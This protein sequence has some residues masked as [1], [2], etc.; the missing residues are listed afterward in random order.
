MTSTVCANIGP[1]ERRK[2]NLVGVAGALFTLLTLAALIETHASVGLRL[3]VIV[4]AFLTA[5]GFLQAR[6][7][8]CVAFAR[9]GIRVL[10]DGAEAERVTDDGMAAAIAAQARKVYVQA[11]VAV[12]ALTLVVMAIP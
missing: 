2:R 1:R 8:T 12:V 3:V 10:G 11:T 7:Q 5:M 6:A 4:P 9:R